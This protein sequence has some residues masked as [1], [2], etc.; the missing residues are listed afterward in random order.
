MR[1][2]V[3]V[4]LVCFAVV[5]VLAQ[6]QGVTMQRGLVLNQAGA[7]V[8]E[9]RVFLF[10]GGGEAGKTTTD[11]T[12]HFDFSGTDAN[13]NVRVFG[14][15][16]SMLNVVNVSFSTIGNP[17]VLHVTA[18]KC[19]SGQ[20]QNGSCFKPHVWN[21][22]PW[23]YGVFLEGG[24][25]LEDRTAYH[26]FSAGVHAG[27]VL[28][29]GFGPGMYK[30]NFEYAVEFTPLWQSYTPQ[31]QRL[32]CPY[33]ATT[34]SQCSGPTTTGGTY[35]GVSIVPIILRL[36]LRHGAKFEPW[37]QGAGG[38]I[39]TTRKYPGIGSLNVADSSQ[40]DPSADTSVW[41][42][43]PQ[44]GIGLHYFPHDTRHSIDFSANAVHI[45][46]A[47][48]GD[49]NPGVNTGVQFTAGYSWWK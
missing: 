24:N 5:G 1:S 43:D 34:A 36:N 44:F 42:F 10:L 2:F 14:Y 4:F 41:N 31:F 27:K 26:F 20:L 30:A 35:R 11:S 13:Y 37:L 39:Y 45:S 23:E 32:N 15:G 19:P 8:A 25:G 29:S 9:A 18:L 38:L 48:L 21:E 46:S 12:G 33:S 40:T 6:G 3:C 47:S 17:T 22:Q 7:P 16:Y 28:T 49:K